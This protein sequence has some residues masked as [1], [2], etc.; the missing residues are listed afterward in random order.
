MYI[1]NNPVNIPDHLT[2]YGDLRNYVR[3]YLYNLHES[4]N[5]RLNK[6]SFSTADLSLLYGGVNLKVAFDVL[7]IVIKR[8]IVATAVPI[9]SW[10]SWTT[11]AKTLIGMYN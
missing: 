4:V 3:N 5:K 8:S 7:Q 9:L 1:S 2:N 10:T 6:P 11:H